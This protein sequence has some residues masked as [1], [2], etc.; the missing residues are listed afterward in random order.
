LAEVSKKDKPVLKTG[1]D[2]VSPFEQLE[3]GD[4]P[5]GS[6]RLLCMK[7][8]RQSIS[9]WLSEKFKDSDVTTVDRFVETLELSLTCLENLEGYV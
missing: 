2:L 1:E 4:D 5:Q 9:S 8:L 7:E 3:R 6:L